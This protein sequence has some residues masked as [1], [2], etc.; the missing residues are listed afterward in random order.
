MID[1]VGGGVRGEDVPGAGVAVAGGAV[2]VVGRGAGVLVADGVEEVIVCEGAGV[3]VVEG[4]VA[5]V[6]A[7]GTDV[8]IAADGVVAGVVI[9]G[10]GTEVHP[11]ANII[12][13]ATMITCPVLMPVAVIM[14]FH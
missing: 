5:V 2:V 1:N 12:E 3:A 8:V 14:S 7:D 4:V 11:A 10:D 6:G 9:V 13:T